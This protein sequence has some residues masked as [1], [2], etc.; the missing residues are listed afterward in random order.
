MTPTPPIN[1]NTVIK[2]GDRV[3]VEFPN[4]A[5]RLGGTV[6]SVITVQGKESRFDVVFSGGNHNQFPIS[7]IIHHVSV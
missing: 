6:L 7:N 5:F 4:S 3:T 1:P 2:N